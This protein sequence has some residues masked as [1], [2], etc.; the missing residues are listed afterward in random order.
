MADMSLN[1]TGLDKVLQN[2]NREVKAI[3]NRTQ[4]GLMTAG[5][6]VKREA[7]LK[8]PVDI[9]N[10][11]ASAYVDPIHDSMG[12][13]GVEIGYTAF[14]APFV[15]EASGKLKGLPRPRPHKGR[16]WDPQGRAE[17]QF[18]RN[19]LYQNADKILSIIAEDAKIR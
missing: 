15:H 4:K 1:L 6:L 19:A 9:G 16:F 18:L 5:L 8:T 12:R 14:Y 7:Q 2:L 3:E 10:L 13:L 11:K 17:P